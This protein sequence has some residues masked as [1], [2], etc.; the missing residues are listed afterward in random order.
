MHEIHDSYFLV[1]VV[2][3]DF[4]NGDIF[5]VFRRTLSK[6]EEAKTARSKNFRDAELSSA[7]ED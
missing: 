3:N 5:S 6:H 1:N 4:M 2:D 7:E